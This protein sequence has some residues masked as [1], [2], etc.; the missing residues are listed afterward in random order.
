MGRDLGYQLKSIC[1][2]E[3]ILSALTKILG[4]KNVIEAFARSYT[5]SNLM[6]KLAKPTNLARWAILAKI[7]C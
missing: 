5:Q 3:S 6:T 2:A 7:G 1:R 4:K